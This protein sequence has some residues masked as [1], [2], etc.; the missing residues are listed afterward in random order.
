MQGGH[1]CFLTI[2]RVGNGSSW[3]ARQWVQTQLS[4]PLSLPPAP[5]VQRT[6][7]KSCSPVLEPQCFLLPGEEPPS[8]GLSRDLR[9][10]GLISH[11]SCYVPLS[12]TPEHPTSCLCPV[13]CLEAF[14]EGLL[15]FWTVHLPFSLESREST[16]VPS[17]P[18]GP[19]ECWRAASCVFMASHSP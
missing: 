3:A 6:R 16:S 1:I 9:V 19:L 12:P 18:R 8:C 4:R 7:L 11:T 2:P 17:L 15:Y 14:Q 13:H 10:P 5:G